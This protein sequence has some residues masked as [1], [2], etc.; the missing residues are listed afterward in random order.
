MAHYWNIQDELIKYG[1]ADYDHSRLYME[2]KITGRYVPRTLI[3]DTKDMYGYYAPYEQEPSA[4]GAEGKVD[5]YDASGQTHRSLFVKY[6]DDPKAMEKDFAGFE[7]E[8]EK[9]KEDKEDRKRDESD[10]DEKA[11]IEKGE[12]EEEEKMRKPK[13]KARKST[14]PI[15][16]HEQELK[17]L[18]AL[19]AKFKFEDSTQYW[20]DYSQVSRLHAPSF[21]VDLVQLGES[22]RGARLR[23]P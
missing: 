14:D 18:Q 2:D 8:D 15:K 19:Y 3:F 22:G 11:E 12:E 17:G 6:L 7:D 9:K 4:E 21:F 5:V 1:H 20:I 13:T 23:R 10:E 16:A